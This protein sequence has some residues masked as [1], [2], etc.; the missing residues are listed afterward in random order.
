MILSGIGNCQSEAEVEKLLISSAREKMCQINDAW[1][2]DGEYLPII[3]SQFVLSELNIHD[4]E[5][6]SN[7]AWMCQNTEQFD[8]QL[9]IVHKFSRLN[10]KYGDGPYYE[11][12]FYYLKKAYAKIPALLEP[13]LKLKPPPDNNA[14]RFLAHSY[15]KMGY[16][17]DFL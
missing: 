4:E 13:A 8:A 1:F 11:A 9:A 16:F 12:Q 3:Q 10:S 6:W 15:E 5:T 2:H 17:S 14:Y 7:L